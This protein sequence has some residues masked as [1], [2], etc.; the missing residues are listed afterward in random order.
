MTGKW[1]FRLKAIDH[2]NGDQQLGDYDEVTVNW[3]SLRIGVNRGSRNK[4]AG[5]GRL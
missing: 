2:C 1:W 4:K 3:A 5:R